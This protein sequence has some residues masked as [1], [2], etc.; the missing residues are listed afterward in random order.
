MPIRI[1]RMSLKSSQV[2]ISGGFFMKLISKFINPQ[3]DLNVAYQTAKFSAIAS[4]IFNIILSLC[5][6]IV[7]ASKEKIIGIDQQGIPYPVEVINQKLSDLISFRQFLSF[8]LTTL[9]SWH[10]DTYEDQM[11]SILAFMS[12]ELKSEYRKY[13]AESDLINKIKRN[14]VSSVI[15]IKNINTDTLEVYQDGYRIRIEA[16][17]ANITSLKD[18]LVQPVEFTIAFRKISPS[19]YNLWGFEVFELKESNL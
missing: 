17:K 6:I 13:I 15:S 18:E 19:K 14:K 9:Y 11:N 16:I 3:A 10:P 12:P 1:L 2:D 4:F 5:L 8:F 7:S